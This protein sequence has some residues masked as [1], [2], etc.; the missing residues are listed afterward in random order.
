MKKLKKRSN[1]SGKIKEKEFLFGKLN[2]EQREM[3]K[4]IG[5]LNKENNRTTLKLLLQ[6]KK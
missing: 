5:K 6:P 2:K 3:R 4:P 1:L